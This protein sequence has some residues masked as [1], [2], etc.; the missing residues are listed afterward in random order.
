MA[1]SQ[2]TLLCIGT[3]LFIV[4]WIAVSLFTLFWGVVLSVSA[5]S[6]DV[7]LGTSFD[8]FLGL[9]EL[10][11]FF[12]LLLTVAEVAVPALLAGLVWFVEI[13]CFL[14]C[15]GGVLLCFR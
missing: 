5:L 9:L 15:L 8:F 4:T 6:F 10:L 14:W 2:L 11:V 1:I 7:F 12:L 3:L 13:E